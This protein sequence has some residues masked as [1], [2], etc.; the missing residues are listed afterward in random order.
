MITSSRGTSRRSFDD[1]DN[2]PAEPNR[3][4]LDAWR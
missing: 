3:L 4:L 2:F 1:S